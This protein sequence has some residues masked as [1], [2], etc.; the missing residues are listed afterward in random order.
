MSAGFPP[1]IT[2]PHTHLFCLGYLY[3]PFT[4]VG[5]VSDKFANRACQGV[6]CCQKMGSW[7]KPSLRARVREMGVTEVRRSKVLAPI[8]SMLLV[9]ESMCSPEVKV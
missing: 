1:P 7:S 6:E 4:L 5:Q 3:H 8:I 9:R 2:S